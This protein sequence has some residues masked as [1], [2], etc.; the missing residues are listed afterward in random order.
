MN[1]PC[2]IRILS[3]DDHPL[4]REG[5]AIVIQN[6]PDLALL[7]EASNAAEA[8]QQFREHQPD[9]TLMNLRLPDLSGIEALLAI[10]AEFPHARIILL[11]TYEGEIDLQRAW[12]AGAWGHIAKTMHPREMVETIRQVHAGRMWVP[13]PTSAQR[14]ERSGEGNLTAREVEVLTRA[15]GG[16][17]IRDIG[18]RLFISENSMR[19]QLKHIFQKLDARD[20]VNAFTIAARRGLS[21]L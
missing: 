21:R 10:R 2:K 8:L 13:P 6:T 4:F 3:V 9:I 17:Q 16:K 20:E 7:G 15:A 19:G 11:C 1:N 18:R 12:Q 5:I 14:A